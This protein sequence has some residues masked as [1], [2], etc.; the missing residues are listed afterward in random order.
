MTNFTHLYKASKE[1]GMRDRHLWTSVFYRPPRSRYTRIERVGVCAAFVYLSMTM[2]AMWY[3]VA[4][5][6]PSAD[7]YFDLGAF[8]LSAEQGAIG[9]IS[10][11][12]VYPVIQLMVAM[13][14]YARPRT[15]KVARSIAARDRQRAEQRE[16]MGLGPEAEMDKAPDVEKGGRKNSVKRNLKEPFTLPWWFRPVAWLLVLAVVGVSV[17]FVWAYAME[18]G[19]QK[20]SRWLT[21][22]LVTFLTS[23][24]IIE[25]V[26]VLLGAVI[27]ATCCSK[28][29]STRVD[30]D[31]V[32]FDEEKTHLY[33][34]EEWQHMKPL[35]ATANRRVHAVKGTSD[36]SL[37]E[38]LR[39]KLVKE[40]EMMLVLRDILAYLAF[41]MMLGFIT[42]G[43]RDPSTFL[44]VS[45]FRNAFI[46][47]GDLYWDYKEKVTH[48]DRY[49]LWLKNIMLKELRAQRW[50]N[51]EPPYGLRGFLGD[52][53]NRI[54]GYGI[55]RQV[56]N[57]KNVCRPP[58]GPIRKIVGSCT[59]PRAMALEDDGDYC[60]HWGDKEVFPGACSVPEFK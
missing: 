44:M 43:S 15:R 49:W 51:D 37:L 21:S 31:D 18:F 60:A 6:K 59:G 30:E 20:T 46:R 29:V 54:M 42:Y 16:E 28:C 48:S 26:M 35:D 41:V 45:H 33:Y 8:S 57:K 19:A 5:E 56:R 4:P 12:A 52:K 1:K 36:T 25:P 40:R 32:D 3:N 27:R 10:L 24:L 22:L 9:L 2:S 14:R 38:S 50:Y 53:Q 55:L 11:V 39:Q 13:F 58:S 7:S 34:D 47:E 17:F 23:L